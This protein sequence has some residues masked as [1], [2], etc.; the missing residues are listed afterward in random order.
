[1]SL[2][3]RGVDDRRLIGETSVKDVASV[4]EKNVGRKTSR[5]RKVRKLFQSLLPEPFVFQSPKVCE[6]MNTERLHTIPS[7]LMKNWYITWSIKGKHEMCIDFFSCD[8]LRI[9]LG[10]RGTREC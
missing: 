5:R 9:D 7:R 6:P 1:M 8:F 4:C 2:F 3:E 10:A